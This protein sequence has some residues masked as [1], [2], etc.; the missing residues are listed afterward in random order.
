MPLANLFSTPVALFE[1]PDLA[2]LNKELT[3]ILIAESK[4]IPSIGRSNL[5]GWHSAYNLQDRSE[6]CFQTLNK[7][8]IAAAH[9]TGQTI[10]KQ[11]GRHLVPV[12]AKTTMWAMVMRHGDSSKPHSHADANWASVYYPDVGEDIEK[13]HP[14]SGAIT[15]VDP[16]N[17]FNYVPGLEMAVGEFV[18]NPKA[19]QLLVFPGWLMHYVSPYKGQRPRVSIAC[20]V[21]YQIIK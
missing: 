3:D 17:G 15:F 16:R 21:F 6:V 2:A 10:A 13:V 11:T 7:M 1:Y 9:E 14:G 20:N 18:V 4:T 12:T 5:G 19:G 8:I